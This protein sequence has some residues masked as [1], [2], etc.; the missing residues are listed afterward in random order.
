MW[1]GNQ[2]LCTQQRCKVKLGILPDEKFSL[3]YGTGMGVKFFNVD[4]YLIL[5]QVEAARAFSIQAHLQ[6]T[7]HEYSLS[8]TTK[9]YRPDHWVCNQVIS[10]PHR[11][12]D[13]ECD[14]FRVTRAIW[15]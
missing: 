4:E 14:S 9:L 1:E 8:I 2:N 11:I 12:S 10:D 5:K 7:L 13:V 6:R 15:E 3:C